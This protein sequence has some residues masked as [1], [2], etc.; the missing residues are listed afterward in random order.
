MKNK[1]IIWIL[2]LLSAALLSLP[3]LV[4]G[5]GFVALFALVPLLLADALA[6]EFRL[7]HFFFYHYSAFVLWNA[8]TTFWVCNATVGGG[9]TA[10]LCN[11]LQM[12]LVWSIFRFSKKSLGGVLPYLLL[13][14]LWIAWEKLYF[15]VDISWPWLV[16]GNAFASSPSMVQWYEYSGSLG[17][18]LWVW[19]SNLLLF[20]VLTVF[21]GGCWRRW[22]TVARI[23]YLVLFIPVLVFPPVLSSKIYRNY[24]EKSEKCLDVVVAQPNFDPYQKFESYSQ[25]RQND[26]LLDLYDNALP[27]DSLSLSRPVLLIAPETFTSDI[28]LDAVPLSP[29]VTSFVEFLQR[30]QNATMI[31]GASTDKIY[32]TRSAPSILARQ[33]GDLWVENHNSALLLRPSGYYEVFHKSKLVVGTELTPYPKLFVPLD[34]WL[35]GLMHVRGLMGRCIGQKEVSLLHPDSLSAVGC[36]VCYESVYGDYCRNYVLKGAGAMTVITNDAWWGDTPGYRQHF[37]YSRLR[38][39]ELRRDIARCGNTGISAFINQKGDVVCESRWWTRQ[40]LTGN[41][42]FNYAE[43]FFVRH[44]DICGRCCTL[45]AILFLLS[46]LVNRLTQKRVG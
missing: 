45:I 9:I 29:T 13:A 40:T 24:E 25:K 39:I 42:N 37:N 15:N 12:S 2:A 16:L 33:Y 31:F 22:N 10:I 20:S 34:N 3:W 28:N 1:G 41:L 36:A 4:Q 44:G 26:I 35:S 19:C 17:G 43:T 46:A 14:S 6:D 11:A 8:L 23:F 27:G 30:H 38:A 5:A 21:A 32:N 18:S 7:K